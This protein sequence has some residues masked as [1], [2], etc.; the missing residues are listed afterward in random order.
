VGETCTSAA[1]VDDTSST[2]GSNGVYANMAIMT[3]EDVYAFAAGSGPFQ[4]LDDFS[5]GQSLFVTATYDPA[6]DFWSSFG[7][8][9]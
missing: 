6:A 4:V 2:F 3:G 9:I 1:A 5:F 8:I 7:P